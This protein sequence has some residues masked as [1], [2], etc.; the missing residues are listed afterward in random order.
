MLGP[1]S[2]F[3]QEFAKAPSVQQHLKG[4]VADWRARDGG[5]SGR[6]VGPR[7]KRAVFGPD[8]FLMDLDAGNGASHF[9]G[10]WGV[11]GEARGDRIDWQ[12]DNDTDTTSLLYGTPVRRMGLPAAPSYKR[13]AP[14]GRTHQSIRFT[15]DLDGVPLR[16]TR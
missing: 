1:D 9:V 2:S 5:L 11:Q 7:A 6:Y 10:S 3:S 4:Y 15:T 8:Q 13:P 12:A 16:T 14:D